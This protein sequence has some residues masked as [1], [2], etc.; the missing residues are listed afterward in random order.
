MNSQRIVRPPVNRTRTS[1][2]QRAGTAAGWMLICTALGFCG[3][4]WLIMQWGSHAN[5]V[6]LSTQPAGS[7]PLQNTDLATQNNAVPTTVYSDV[8]VVA[9][10]GI[11]N[12]TLPYNPDP[13]GT[14]ITVLE[15][16]GEGIVLVGGALLGGIALLLFAARRMTRIPKDP[17]AT[18][19]GRTLTLLENDHRGGNLTPQRA[20]DLARQAVADIQRDHEQTIAIRTRAYED[21]V[22]QLTKSHTDAIA[23]IR[24]EATQA[25]KQSQAETSHANT[26][27][28]SALQRVANTEVQVQQ[29]SR[30]LATTHQQLVEAHTVIRN[31]TTEMNDLNQGLSEATDTLIQW[32]GAHREISDHHQRL[33]AEHT[34][35]QTAFAMTEATATEMTTRAQ[36]AQSDAQLLQTETEALR[37]SQRTLTE[38]LATCT[39]ELSRL[40]GVS[41]REIPITLTDREG[42]LT[43]HMAALVQFIRGTTMD[44]GAAGGERTSKPI[45]SSWRDIRRLFQVLKGVGLRFA[46]PAHH[47]PQWAKGSIAVEISREEQETEEVGKTSSNV[48]ALTKTAVPAHN[49]GSTDS[50]TSEAGVSTL[51]HA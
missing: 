35:L 27:A 12:M 44:S 40:R 41:L 31:Q 19:L 2:P 14:L 10:Q 5:A 23:A 8:P 29:L 9:R 28:E 42:D 16:Q 25:V 46:V 20:L 26:R 17:L 18:G 50:S 32:Q 33:R 47:L 22:A 7:A 37:H 34:D 3:V 21:A 11:E 38:E 36:K 24:T 43:P 30:D 51:Q 49:G 15:Q 39:K 6:A 48:Q 1:A 13:M 4:A 45:L